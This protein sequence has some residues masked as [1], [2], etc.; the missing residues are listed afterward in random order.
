MSIDARTIER[1]AELASLY[2]SDKE[3]EQYASQLSEILSYVEKIKQ[4]DTSS[5]EPTS[6]IA[7]LKNVFRADTVIPSIDP[8]EIRAIAPSF[9]RGHI[10]VPKIIDG[11]A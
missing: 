11:E 6:H 10:V 4:L 5:V 3:K 7:G 8:E 1:T 9:E 2:I